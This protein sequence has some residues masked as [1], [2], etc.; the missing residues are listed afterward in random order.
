MT[1]IFSKPAFNVDTA[2]S[3]LL[4]LFGF[5]LPLSVAANNLFAVSIIVLWLYRKEYQKTWE[6][7]K[8]SKIVIAVLLFVLLHIIGL[9]WTE[10]VVSG[11]KIV[12][13]EWIFLLLPIMMSFVRKEH[14]RYYISAFL[15][16]ISISEIFS[17]LI[18]FEVVPPFLR[19][20]LYD[21][22]PFIH[23]T[24]YNPF[25]ALAIYLTG[26]Y[27]L[28]DK[29]LN[30][31]QKIVLILFFFTMGTN[32]FITGGRAGQ[33][34]YFVMVTILFFQFFNKHF[35]RALFLSILFL[36]SILF[37]AYFGSQIF[38]DRMNEAVSQI[39]NYHHD[40]NITTGLTTVNSVGLR[41]NFAIN[42]LEIIKEHPLIGVG[43]GGFKK[44]YK[45]INDKN[46]PYAEISVHPHNMYL[47]EMVQ[48]G[49]FGLI[50]LLSI[51]YFQLRFAWKEKDMLRSRVGIALPLLFSV[52]MLSDSYLLGHFTTMLFVFF[53]AFLYRPF[54]ETD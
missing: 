50:S 32:M 5:T 1:K 43:T 36:G 44:S 4:I 39:Q 51:L 16:A 30:C 24:S 34:G 33:V 47:F 45:I 26:Y 54:N 20:T 8:N 15:I 46:S 2:G 22:T 31:V 37:M 14:I 3:W 21:P 27:V 40:K 19:A 12:K 13:K 42:T 6:M 25:L 17:Y 10:D 28:F 49:I 29:T 23:H 53:S 41:I 11:L 18:W 35:F 9:L 38:Q 52:I 7:I 48:F